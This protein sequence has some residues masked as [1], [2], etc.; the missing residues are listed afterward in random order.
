MRG[1]GSHAIFGPKKIYYAVVRSSF[2]T[3]NDV[4]ILIT[5]VLQ[6]RNT[7]LHF[8]PSYILCARN[9]RN[10]ANKTLANKLD[11]FTSTEQVILPKFCIFCNFCWMLLSSTKEVFSSSLHPLVLHYFTLPVQPPRLIGS[12]CTWFLALRWQC[13]PGIPWHYLDDISLTFRSEEMWEILLIYFSKVFFSLNKSCLCGFPRRFIWFKIFFPVCFFLSFNTLHRKYNSLQMGKTCATFQRF[14]KVS[15]FRMKCCP[16]FGRHWQERDWP[17]HPPK[18]VQQHSYWERN[19]EESSNFTMYKLRYHQS[20]HTHTHS[21][22]RNQ[23]G[24]P[25][26]F[27]AL[28]SCIFPREILMRCCQ[29]TFEIQSREE[30]K[31]QFAA[32]STNPGWIGV[33]T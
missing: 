23:P 26:T 12:L 11:F 25:V 22:T 21:Q 33:H 29:N 28:K 4:H 32:A 31:K 5:Q 17:N 15:Q 16:V 30:K 7:C 9:E 27:T 20:F 8:L 1:N 13:C 10:T 6:Q 3:A 14:S 24:M 2:H 19:N 18:N